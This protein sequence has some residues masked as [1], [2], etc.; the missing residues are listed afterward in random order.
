MS[1]YSCDGQGITWFVDDA[2]WDGDEEYGPAWFFVL[3]MVPAPPFA[4][5]RDD[6]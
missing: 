5:G 4:D 2:L 1:C 3:P 6:V